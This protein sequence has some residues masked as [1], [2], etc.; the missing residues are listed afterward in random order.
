M[1]NTNKNPNKVQNLID[2]LKKVQESFYN[3]FGVDDILTN[4]KIYEI[5]IANQLKHDLIPGH[6]GSRDAHDTTG[7]F[8]YKHYK[9]SSSNHTWTFNDYSENTIKKLYQVKAVIF[10]HFDDINHYPA[11]FD[12]YYRVPGEIIA[13]YLNSKIEN[14]TNKRKMIN[15]SSK[16]IEEMMGIGRTNVDINISK[17]KFS[18]WIN[19][20]FNIAKDLEDLLNTRNILTS[21]K[22]WELLV[23]LILNHTVISEQT[24]FDATDRFGNYYEYKVAKNTNWSFEDISDEVLNKFVNIKEIIL[25]VVDKKKLEI[26]KIYSADPKIIVDLLRQKL[27]EKSVNYSSKGKE[28]R[29]L[30]VSLSKKDLEK[31]GAKIIYL[32]P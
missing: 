10:A 32:N 13:K 6:S 12:W 3:E 19:N 16:Q 9:E 2:Q 5:I 17:G 23:G 4:S 25:A 20:I 1:K 11:V 8:E 21:N 30:Q 27:K 22:F 31:V 14:I 28:V 24:K 7:E 29:R 26:T 15:V 18:E